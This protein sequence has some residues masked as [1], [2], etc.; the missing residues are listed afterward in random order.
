MSEVP[1]H[2]ARARRVVLGLFI[3]AVV[4]TTLVVVVVA[5]AL[6]TSALPE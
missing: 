6:L 2:T 4:L 3:A 5:G 1:E